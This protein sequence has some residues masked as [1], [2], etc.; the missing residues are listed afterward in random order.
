MQAACPAALM[1]PAAQSLHA[2]ELEPVASM[3]FPGTHVTHTVA[4]FE[5]TLVPAGQATQSVARPLPGLYRPIA[6]SSQPSASGETADHLPGGHSLHLV[7]V[8]T[9]SADE[10]LPAAQFW[11]VLDASAPAVLLHLPAPQGSQV[12][13]S[14]LA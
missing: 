3:Y 6:Q 12:S 2:L 11:H 10:Y 5:A 4:P 14:A 13:W 8:S 9:P 7:A 1:R